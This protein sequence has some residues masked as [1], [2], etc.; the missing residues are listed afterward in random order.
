MFVLMLMGWLQSV[1]F[2]CCLLLGV[3]KAKLVIKNELNRVEKVAS[4]SEKK[5]KAVMRRR[6]AASRQAQEARK[7]NSRVLDNLKQVH[8][9]QTQLLLLLLLLLGV[10]LPVQMT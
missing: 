8:L 3:E 10:T 7:Q 9:L 4:D 5:L 2:V 6:Q 1:V